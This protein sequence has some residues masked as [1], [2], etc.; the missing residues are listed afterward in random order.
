M[1][2]R[3]KGDY[4]KALDDLDEAVRLDPQLAWAY[5]NRGCVW[6]DVREYAKALAD[7]E[8]AMRLDAKEADFPYGRAVLLFMDRRD[9]VVNEVK[10]VLRLKNWQGDMPIYS[11]ILGH[12]AALRAGQTEQARSF[13]DD[14]A[15]RCDRSAW[16]Y[17]VVCYLR[18]E[19]DLAAL[20]AAANG[21]N[22]MT[23]ARCFLGLEALHQGRVENALAHFHWVKENGNPRFA[24]YAMSLAEL[25]RLDRDQAAGDGP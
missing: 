4:T 23:E 14:A 11:V 12:F 5:N 22:R 1:A 6:R 15:R 18:G 13:L 16:P 19:I 20:L 9:G 8:H 24:Q 21:N 25:G 3:S 2:W 10:K 7:F 17:P